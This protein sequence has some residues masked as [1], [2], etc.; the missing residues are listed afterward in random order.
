[1]VAERSDSKIKEK[2]RADSRTVDSKA[3][4]FTKT[5]YCDYSKCH[6]KNQEVMFNMLNCDNTMMTV[7]ECAKILCMN[8]KSLRESI[9]NGT[10]E[11]GRCIRTKKSKVYK[12]SRTA[13]MRWLNGDSVVQ[14]E[15]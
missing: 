4:A 2:N 7:E 13:F 11:F 6:F 10:F 8:P 15:V 14:N 9:E 1:M 3:F 12:I 5:T